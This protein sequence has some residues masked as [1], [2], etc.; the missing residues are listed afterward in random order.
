LRAALRWADAATR[1]SVRTE[2]YTA[3]GSRLSGVLL[4][5]GNVVIRVL[6]VRRGPEMDQRL[7]N[8]ERSTHRHSP[9]DYVDE[10][11]PWDERDVPWRR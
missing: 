3:D 7:D 11:E 8:G 2:V 9:Q 10:G 4:V 5:D 1:P 6:A